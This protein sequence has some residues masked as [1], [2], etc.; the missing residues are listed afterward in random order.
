L[1]NYRDF[2]CLNFKNVL[3]LLYIASRTAYG[4]DLVEKSVG[5]ALKASFVHH[6]LVDARSVY[7]RGIKQLIKNWI[8]HSHVREASQLQRSDVVE[9]VD[10]NSL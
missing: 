4:A 3:S 6:L 9:P 5:M 1:E 10:L 8:A 2:C 7:R